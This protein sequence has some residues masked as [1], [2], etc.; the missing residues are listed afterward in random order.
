MKKIKFYILTVLCAAAACLLPFSAFADFSDVPEEHWA[1]AVIAEAVSAGIMNGRSAGEFGLGQTVTQAEF[2]AMLR[3]LMQWEQA[4]PQQPSFSDVS[5]DSWYFSEVEAALSGGALTGGGAFRP[6]DAITREEMAVMLVRALGFGSLA[7][8]AG[9]PPFAD[10]STNAGYIAVAYEFGIINGKGASTFDPNGSA[11][12]E[13]AAAM[14]MRLHDKYTHKLDWLHGFYAISSWS[15]RELA[16]E[17]DSV[18][19]GWARLEYSAEKGVW[20][21]TTGEGGNDWKIPDGAQDAVTF[22]KERGVSLNL[23]VMMNTSQQA[24]LADG[25]QANACEAVLTDAQNRAAAV[26]QI[27]AAAQGYDGVTIDFEGMKGAALR[28]GL[29]NFLTEL[30][31]ALGDK[32]IYT[33]VH[34]VM[35]G[36]YFDAYDYRAIGAV[37]D[38]VILMA[39]DYAALR[40]EENLREAGFTAT[41]VTPQAS[42]YTALRAITDAETGVADTDK[43]VLAVSLSS[44]AAWTLESGK[45]TNEFAIHPAMETVIKRLRQPDTAITYHDDYKNPSAKY[46]DDEGHTVVLWYEDSRSVTDKIRLARMFGINKLS[47]WRIGAIPNDPAGGIHYDIWDAISNER[48]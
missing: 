12:R 23:A 26:S 28:Q 32:Q 25:T 16:G 18:S 40:M 41:P 10:V 19:F 24:A 30:R 8:Q 7:T 14:M 43:I 15:Q 29:N 21:N 1:S 37:S 9:A 38:R 48:N 22:L 46:T 4:A 17:M 47:I 39:H 11:L 13:E 45:V 35:D 42:V 27:A 31:A 34:P 3:R 44:T 2:A 33:A 6:E 36:E 5:P 20:L